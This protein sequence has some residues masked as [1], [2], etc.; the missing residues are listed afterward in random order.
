MNIPSI[1]VRIFSALLKLYPKPFRN[2]FEEEMQTVF[3]AW[4]KDHTKDGLIPLMTSCLFEYLD[5]L[6]NLFYE[7]WVAFQKAYQM[8]KFLYGKFHNR[9]ILWGGFVFGLANGLELLFGSL[10]GLNAVHITDYTLP[11][12]LASYLIQL[13]FFCAATGI[14]WLSTPRFGK[15]WRFLVPVA[16]AGVISIVNFLVGVAVIINPQ[17]SRYLLEWIW[18]IHYPEFYMLIWSLVFGGLFGWAYRGWKA[19]APFALVTVLK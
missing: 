11:T 12:L 3:A 17:R 10:T 7:Y 5:L 15:K 14:F 9:L 2:E 8:D 19:I 13:L 16:G 1:S 4:V 18:T 6:Y